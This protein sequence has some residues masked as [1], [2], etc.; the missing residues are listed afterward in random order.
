[1]NPNCTPDFARHG[2]CIDLQVA[3]FITLYRLWVLLEQHDLFDCSVRRPKIRAD[4]LSFAMACIGIHDQWL[5][6]QRGRNTHP[7]KQRCTEKCAWLEFIP[8]KELSHIRLVPSISIDHLPSITEVKSTFYF[9]G[10][11]FD[12]HENLQSSQSWPAVAASFP[13]P[14]R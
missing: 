10:Y 8:W 12:S 3:G 14:F 4:P 13:S 7:L 2:T 11:L 6:A 9:L 5:F 1:M